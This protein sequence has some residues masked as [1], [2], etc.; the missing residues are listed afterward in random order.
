MSFFRTYLYPTQFPG[1]RSQG[2][3]S[4]FRHQIDTNASDFRCPCPQVILSSMYFEI[5]CG[6]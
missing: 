4:V 1:E 5:V 2:N 3:K 6:L